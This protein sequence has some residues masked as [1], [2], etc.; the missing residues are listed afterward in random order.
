MGKILLAAFLTIL[1]LIALLL[2]LNVRVNFGVRE[3]FWYRLHVAGIRVDP[4]LFAKKHPGKGKRSSKKNKKDKK[5]RKKEKQEQDGTSEEGQTGKKKTGAADKVS[6]VFD[7][8]KTALDALPKT[9]R[10]T[11]RRLRVTVGGEDAADTALLY[12]RLY[13]LISGSLALLDAYRGPF[14]GF[15]V[16]R[17]AVAL[18][19]DFLRRDT[20]TDIEVSVSFFVWQLLFTAVRLG[21]TYLWHLLKNTKEKE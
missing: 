6:L 1:A 13:A 8:L 21:V 4:A 9:V 11:L 19:T 2:L 15:R 14:Y 18:S 16:R 5:D 17:G 12:G 20:A 3:G 10:V 7:L